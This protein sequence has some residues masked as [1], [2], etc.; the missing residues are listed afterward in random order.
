MRLLNEALECDCNSTFGIFNNSPY[1]VI[2]RTTVLGLLTQHYQKSGEPIKLLILADHV[3]RIA[4][5]KLSLD[6]SSQP[7][8]EAQDFGRSVIFREGWVWER[9]YYSPRGCDLVVDPLPNH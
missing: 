4:L 3:V 1:T 8:Q 5:P 7:S 9:D 2:C 6:Y